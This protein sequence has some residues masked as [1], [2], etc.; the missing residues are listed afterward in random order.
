MDIQLIHYEELE[1][2]EVE[3]VKNK[4]KKILQILDHVLHMLNINISCFNY[5]CKIQ[6]IFMDNLFI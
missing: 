5:Y 4:N 6:Y 1:L 2:N 3:N